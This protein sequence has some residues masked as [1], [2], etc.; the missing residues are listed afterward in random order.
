MI[1]W[2][3][4]L[5]IVFLVAGL[6]AGC[7]GPWPSHSPPPV[8]TGA[9]PLWQDGSI[10]SEVSS[11]LAGTGRAGRLWVEMY[12]FDRPDLESALLAARDRGADVRLIVDPTVDVSRQ[13]AGRLAAAG[14]A[15]RFYPVDDRAHQIDHVK[16][17]WTDGAA[18]V[19]GMNWGRH[20]DANHDYA[21]LTR[22]G[23]EL[24][25]LRAIY[26]QDW[27]LAG[28]RA[29]PLPPGPGTIAQTA[30]G[31]EIRALLLAAIEGAQRRVDAEIY[32]L[33]DGQVLAALAAARL[34]GVLVRVIVDPHQN[35]NLPA[36]RDLQAGGIE[37][38]GYPVPRG[39]LLHAKAGLFDDRTLLLGSANWTQ[40]GLSINHELDLESSD[41]PAA[42][43]F[44]AR[45]ERDW[46]A[47]G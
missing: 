7:A 25:R 36:V 3:P 29:E 45:F 23:P 38:R 18:L 22:N 11:L 28:A 34:R 24:E 9:G 37:V 47:S 20:S 5:L 46:T 13:T 41:P 2:P 16:L 31:Q 4:R 43:A 30:P 14:L 21:L 44:A 39:S 26:A 6:A 42:A 32:T 40:G 1:S 27:S 17:L 10:F 35:A 15:V 19:G 12:E 8:P 33:T